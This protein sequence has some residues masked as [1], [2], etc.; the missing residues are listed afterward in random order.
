MPTTEG[1][2]A[3]LMAIAQKGDAKAYRRLLDCL[4]MHL[5]GHIRRLLARM[6]SNGAAEL[7]DILQETLLAVHGR[8]HTY[9]PA[10][11]VT[12]WVNAIARYKLVDHYRAVGDARRKIPIDDVDTL[13]SEPEAEAVDAARDVERLL[14]TLPANL[15][16]P[17]E[18]VKLKGLS[19]AEAAQAA[20]VSQ[21]AVKVSIHRGMKR[22]IARF[23]IGAPTMAGNG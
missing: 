19:I 4:S 8:L 17:I 10:Y 6:G 21:A 3:A 22:L 18:E 9:D 14:S 15:R 1:E 16:R 20:G 12:A 11:P 2:L 23:G 5:K 13:M 7:D